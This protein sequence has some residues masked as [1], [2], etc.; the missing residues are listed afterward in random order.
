MEVWLENVVPRLSGHDVAAGLRLAWQAMGRALRDPRHCSLDPRQRICAHVFRTALDKA[1]KVLEGPEEPRTSFLAAVAAAGARDNLLLALEKGPAGAPIELGVVEAA[2]LAGTL[3]IIPAERLTPDCAHTLMARVAERSALQELLAVMDWWGRPAPA[4]LAVQAAGH[5]HAPGMWP[6]LWPAAQP[7]RPARFEPI[8][9]E[10]Y[11]DMVWAAAQGGHAASVQFLV[12][13]AQDAAV[14]QAVREGWLVNDLCW[15]RQL[16][17]KLY[18]SSPRWR[19]D[20]AARREEMR[21]VIE[22]LETDEARVCMCL[23][24]L[25]CAPNELD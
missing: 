19:P 9:Y 3:E 8:T 15:V 22:W 5:G 23:P 4:K 21:P 14:P 18:M 1:K 11:A 24:P 17:Y 20:H 2:Q 12:Q 7:G 10:V 25:D 13:H 6:L 16:G